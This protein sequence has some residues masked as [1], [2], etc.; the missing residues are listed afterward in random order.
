MHT[1]IILLVLLCGCA[2]H[3]NT[4]R[5]KYPNVDPELKKYV[6]R[7]DYFYYKHRKKFVTNDIKVY[8]RVIK[9]SEQA[10]GMYHRILNETT[11]SLRHWPYW[12]EM[13]REE[14][15]FHELG[16]HVLNLN[17]DWSSN[18]FFKDK[19]PRTIMY[20]KG[21]NTK[22]YQK[23]RK[24]YIHELFKRGKSKHERFN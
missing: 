23:R 13:E 7:F 20:Y 24:Y 16:H 19:C 15:I 6:M 1:I 14:V 3:N 12:T 17:H 21:I 9:E 10:G 4:I 11:I 18:Q 22:C 5:N 2:T 8:L